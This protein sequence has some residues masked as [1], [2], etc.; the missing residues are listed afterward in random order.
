MRGETVVKKPIVV[1]C[2]VFLLAVVLAGCGSSTPLS[3]SGKTYLNSDETADSRTVQFLPDRTFVYSIVTA[4][5]TVKNSGNYSVGD[6]KVVLLFGPGQITELAGKT[7]EFK[8]DG[9]LLVDPDGTRWMV[10]G[11]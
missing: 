10:Y 7:Q 9:Q 11:K 2:I 4:E 6:K 1:V 3:V 8:Q 5:T